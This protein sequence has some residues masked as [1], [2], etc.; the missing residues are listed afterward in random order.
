MKIERLPSGSYRIRKMYKGKTYSI[1]T[2]HKP[3]QKEALQLLAE[4][5]SNVD[6]NASRKDFL[7]HANKYIEVKRNVLS[8]STVRG[9]T[10]IVKYLPKWFL[11]L[12]ISDITQEDVQRMINEYSRP[13]HPMD[14]TT[15]KPDI[16][17]PPKERTA[18]SVRNAHGLV[19]AVLSMYRPNLALHTTLPQKKRVEHYIPTPEDVKKIMELAKGTRYEIV[20]GLGTYGMRRSEICALTIDDVEG[21]MVHI[22]KALVQDDKG[23]F[24]VKNTTKTESSTRNIII[25]EHLSNLIHEQGFVY[26]GYPGKISEN[27]SSMQE[28]AGVPHFRFHDLRHF[29][30]TELSQAGVSDADIMYLGGW[31][32][33]HV[34]KS[35]YRHARADKDLAARTAAASQIEKILS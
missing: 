18:K 15:G 13:Y 2:D 22:N 32:S 17:K 9:Y 33:D 10:F 26:D 30:A 8:P 28:K 25:S 1:V 12:R 3:T 21:R 19:S 14:K 31:S 24:V 27:L 5:L 34:M 23:D 7:Y 16:S 6:D 4:K 20:F 29:F 35:V 11:D